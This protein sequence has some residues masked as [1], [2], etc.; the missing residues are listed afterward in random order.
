EHLH[1]ADGLIAVGHGEELAEIDRTELQLLLDLGPLAADLG[2]LGQCGLA[3]FGREWRRLR[4]GRNDS[5]SA[6]SGHP[7]WA[8]GPTGPPQP[9]WRRRRSTAPRR[10]ER[11]GAGGPA[12]RR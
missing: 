6:A 11:H 5:A 1:L 3:L 2:G 7:K 8:R 10:A 4:H 9:R 12:R